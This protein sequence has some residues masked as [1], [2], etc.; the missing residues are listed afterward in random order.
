[1]NIDDKPSS[2][3]QFDDENREI[4]FSRYDMPT[5]WMN[6]LSNETFHVMM[7]H[8]GGGVAFYKSPQI[9]RINHYKFFHIPAD[10]SGFYTYIKDQDSVWCPTSQPVFD[11]PEQ[12]ESTHG[13]GYT[14]FEAKKQGIRAEVDYFV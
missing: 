1:M 7:S 9:W 10:R 6:Y 2:Y 13:M 3:Y 5:P 12:W 11:K 8:A 4:H 14:R